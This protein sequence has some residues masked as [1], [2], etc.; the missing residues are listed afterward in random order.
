MEILIHSKNTRFAVINVFFAS[1]LIVKYCEFSMLKEMYPNRPLS[2]DQ[3]SFLKCL[4]YLTSCF[5]SFASFNSLIS[6]AAVLNR[7][8]ILSHRLLFL[9][10]LFIIFLLNVTYW[11][12][13]YL[14]I[15]LKN[16]SNQVYK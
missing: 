12:S 6:L 1:Y 13:Q 15:F 7:H 16:R 5:S 11:F 2:P 14:V 9:L 8:C 4:T 10:L 3:S